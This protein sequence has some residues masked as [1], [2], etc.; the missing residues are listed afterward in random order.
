MKENKGIFYISVTGSDLSPNRSYSNFIAAVCK[1]IINEEL[2]DIFKADEL[3]P[4]Y[5][6]TSGNI[7]KSLFDQLAYHDTFVVLLNTCDKKY[8]PNVW[9]ELGAI[10]TRRHCKIIAIAEK[11]VDI[12]FDVNEIKVIQFERLGELWRSKAFNEEVDFDKI[13]DYNA[14]NDSIKSGKWMNIYELKK[15]MS[16]N[17]ENEFKNFKREFCECLRNEQYE[18]PFINYYENS[19]LNNMG[20]RSF[21]DYLEDKVIDIATYISGEHDAFEA[22]TEAIKTAKEEL[23]TSRF[24]NQS[25]VD[26]VDNE[27]DDVAKAHENFRYALYKTSKNKNISVCRRIVCNNNAEKWKDIVNALEEGNM[28]VYIRKKNYNIN[29]ELVVIDRKTAFI[30]FYQTNQSGDMDRSMTSEIRH[31]SR[32]Q[33]INSTLRIRGT[34][35]CEALARVFDRLIFRDETGKDLSRTLLGIEPNDYK[36]NETKAGYF[37]SPSESDD[38]FQR[39]LKIRTDIIFAYK[40]WTISDEDKIIM[41]VGLVRELGFEKD[42]LGISEDEY[43]VILSKYNEIVHDNG[44]SIPVNVVGVQ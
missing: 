30:H 36:I 13:T 23:R 37:I 43:D 29:F 2:S 7:K 20:Y 32:T 41:T 8:N 18:N 44:A 4:H 9:F 28:T 42:L 1:N 19:V 14:D 25:I 40:N 27:K 35:V 39:R 16:T 15:D 21:Q 24:A 22:L 11:G 6:M 3:K 38:D 10:S 12:P 34:D 33:R 5:E 17:E 26:K 31:D